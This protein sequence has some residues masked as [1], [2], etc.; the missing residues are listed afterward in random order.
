MLAIDDITPLP[1]PGLIAG[2]QTLAAKRDAIQAFV[3]AT[4]QAMEEISADPELGL[5]DAIAVVPDLA[6]N[7][8]AQLA[9]LEATVEAWHSPYTQQHGLGAIDQDAWAASLDFMRDLADSNIPAD[10]TVDQLV[11][12]ELIAE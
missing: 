6:T 2:E 8:D 4:L 1:G 7:R 3:D 10:L 5:E 9:V 11:T 12:T